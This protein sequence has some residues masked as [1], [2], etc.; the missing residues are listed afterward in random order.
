MLVSLWKVRKS[1]AAVAHAQRRLPLPYDADRLD[2]RQL[3]AGSA[4]GSTA[5][6]LAMVVTATAAASAAGVV[7]A[8]V[9]RV[10]TDQW[11]AID[12]CR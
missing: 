12:E 1:D 7:R 8:R 5:R 6:R 9:H 4:T 2:R 3:H 10:G 11:P